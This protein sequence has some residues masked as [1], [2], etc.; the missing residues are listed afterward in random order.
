MTLKQDRFLKINNFPRN[1][2]G[3]RSKLSQV[4]GLKAALKIIKIYV[5]IKQKSYSKVNRSTDRP[6]HFSKRSGMNKNLKKMYNSQDIN[7]K[8]L[9]LKLMNIMILKKK[10][11][12]QLNWL[13]KR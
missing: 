5:L 11:R 13:N 4:Q 9:Q 12:R 3:K 7:Q 1:K 8:T 6:L 2:Q 10:K